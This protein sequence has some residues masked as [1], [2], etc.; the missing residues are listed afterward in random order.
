LRNN[1][2]Q[3]ILNLILGGNQTDAVTV[4]PYPRS[5]L[6]ALRWPTSLAH[7]P[8]TDHAPPPARPLFDII[9]DHV[10]AMEGGYTDDAHDPGG[11]TNRGITL[12][13]Y[14]AWRNIDVTPETF[15]PLKAELR[16]LTR[17]T[18]TTIY[19]AR[20][21]STSKAEHLPPALLREALGLMAGL[22]WDMGSGTT[23]RRVDASA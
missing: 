22:Y 1:E 18:A 8:D 17:E 2:G 20:Y 5:R 3:E 6:L 12:A 11:P 23:P 10:L 9:L 13:T 16:A 15:G 19:R 7:V 4:A 14:A 21:W